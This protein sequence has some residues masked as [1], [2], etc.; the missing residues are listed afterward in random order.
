MRR[1]VYFSC[2]LLLSCVSVLAQN[3]KVRVSS[4]LLTQEKTG[5][6]VDFPDGA[7]SKYSLQTG[8]LLIAIDSRNADHMGPLAML[9]AFNAAFHRAVPLTVQRDTQLNKISLWR[10]DGPP[11]STS[12]KQE[13]DFV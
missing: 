5:W 7:A 3:S 13:K 8:D 11:P 10:S 9:G 2:C 12:T 6:R 4:L 1:T